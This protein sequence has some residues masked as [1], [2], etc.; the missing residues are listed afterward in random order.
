MRINHNVAATGAYRYLRINSDKSARVLEK[1]SSGKRINRAADDAT[2]MAISE[3]MNS[4]IQGLRMA[5]RNTLDG[6]SLIQTAEGAL[7][8]VHSI[9]QRIRELT[10]QAAN[11]PLQEE[12][13]QTIQGEINE[14]TSEINRIG[15]TTEFNKQKLLCGDEDEYKTAIPNLD[16]HLENGDASTKASKEFDFSSIKGANVTETNEKMKGLVGKG[17]IINGKAIEFYDS[18]KGVYEGDHI[19]VDIRSA[20][21]ET[22]NDQKVETILNSIISE[23]GG[24]M[25]DVT[26]AA[27]GTPVTNLKVEATNAGLDGNKI[28]IEDGFKLD[29]KMDLQIGANEGQSLALEI[30]DMRAMSLGISANP[31]DPGFSAIANVSN[32]SGDNF[33]ESALDVVTAGNATKSLAK[34]D[35]AIKRVSAMRSRLGAY[36]NRLE[37]TTTNIDNTAENLTAALSRIQDADMALEMSEFTKLNILQQSGTAM[38]A[39]ANQ[40]PQSILQLLQ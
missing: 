31:G 27:T 32:D 29:Y 40:R 8:E 22:N 25:K 30:G 6:I 26:I 5:S 17:M 11:G 21:D 9:V 20:I 16:D 2:G 37:K 13:R 12:D 35:E 34:L 15:N 24:K 7:N 39:Q 18:L 36:Q 10:V 4:Q 33:I 23:A 14:L 1:L 19:G 38:L 28:K 3:K